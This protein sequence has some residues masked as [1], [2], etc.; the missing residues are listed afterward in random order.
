MLDDGQATVVIGDDQIA[1]MRHH[2]PVGPR[3]DGQ[4]LNR[5]LDDGFAL[6]MHEHAVLDEGTIK[7]AKRIIVAISAAQV[8][9]DQLFALCDRIGQPQHLHAVRQLIQCRQMRRVA[10]VDENQMRRPQTGHR[11]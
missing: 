4:N 3:R 5:L 1:R 7:R 11:E 10:A 9:G 8:F 2:R 6:R